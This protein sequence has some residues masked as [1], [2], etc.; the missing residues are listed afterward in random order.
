MNR[1][2]TIRHEEKKYH[3]SCYDNYK[4]FEPGTWLHRPVRTV[5]DLLSQFEDYERL[6]V[7]DLGSGIG[8]NSIPI[9]EFMKD[10]RGGKVVCVDF[11]ESAFGKLAEYAVQYEVSAFI[12]PV[13]S[14]IDHYRIEPSAFDLIVAVSTLEHVSS[15]QAL[16]RKLGEMADGTRH[17]GINC[18][19]IGSNIQETVADTGEALDPMFEVNLPTEAMMELLDRHYDGW[20]VQARLV[21]PLVYEIDRDGRPVRLET[22]GITYVAKRVGVKR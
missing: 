3:D 10:G 5:L 14:D 20:E 13:L 15:E 17:N 9:A 19:V 11:L 16:R 8:R 12:E 18:I 4:L 2:Q 7:L 6:D 1:L 22:D 21:K